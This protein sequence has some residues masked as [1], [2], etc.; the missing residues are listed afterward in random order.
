[1]PNESEFSELFMK[2]ITPNLQHVPATTYFAAALLVQPCI[3]CATERGVQVILYADRTAQ[4]SQ[5]GGP[6][7]V[8]VLGYAI[9]HE[10]GHVLLHSG[11]HEAAGLMKDIWTRRDWQRAAVEIIPFSPTEVQR[12]VALHERVTDRDIPEL[13]SLKH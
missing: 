3:P 10:L 2:P 7:F 11:D 9:A 13:A 4:V 5:A 12:I 8:R 1:M 6:T